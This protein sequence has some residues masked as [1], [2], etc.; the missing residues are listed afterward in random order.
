M[1][2]CAGCTTTISAQLSHSDL[3]WSLRSWGICMLQRWGGILASSSS[4]SSHSHAFTGI[5]C[6]VLFTYLWSSVKSVKKQRLQPPN[7]QAYS[8]PYLFLPSAL[9][10]LVWILL[11]IYLLLPVLS[12]IV[13]LPLLIDYQ[14]ML[15]L[16]HVYRL[17]LLWILHSYSAIFLSPDLVCLGLLLVIE[18]V[19]SCLPFGPHYYSCL[20]V[21][22]L[23]VLPTIL[24]QMVRQSVSIALLSRFYAL[25]PCTLSPLGTS[26]YSLLLLL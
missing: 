8:N 16:F 9:I 19:S 11:H 22:V 23:W 20:I 25:T 12:M 7:H 4:I 18:I 26:T 24:R 21:R 2:Y 17:L 14:S 5:I 15:C 1:V 3:I 6:A 10:V 13:S